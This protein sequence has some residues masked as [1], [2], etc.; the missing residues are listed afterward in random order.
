MEGLPKTRPPITSV[1]ADLTVQTRASPP[2]TLQGRLVADVPG[3]MRLTVRDGDT[4]VLDLVGDERSFRLPPAAHDGAE[5]TEYPWDGDPAPAT[6]PVDP[7]L[8]YALMKYLAG[9]QASGGAA[10][11]GRSQGLRA[12]LPHQQRHHAP[13]H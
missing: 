4:V 13:A 7:R 9:T 8:F 2:R 5:P 10:G 12:Q 1:S 3:E 11:G 6:D